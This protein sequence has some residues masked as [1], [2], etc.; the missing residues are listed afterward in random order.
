MYEG[1]KEFYIRRGKRR[2]SFSNGSEVF[3]ST[4]HAADQRA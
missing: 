1:E 2:E 3:I 4:T